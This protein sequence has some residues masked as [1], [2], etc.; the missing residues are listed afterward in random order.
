MSAASNATD[1]TD[2]SIER[3]EPPPPNTPVSQT[4]RVPRHWDRCGGAQGRPSR[5][6]FVFLFLDD[7]PRVG[8]NVLAQKLNGQMRVQ[9][10]FSAASNANFRDCHA[11]TSI[12]RIKRR[13]ERGKRREKI[14][15]LLTGAPRR[16]QALD[17]VRFP[18]A[19]LRTD[20][21]PSCA[22]RRR[23]AGSPPSPARQDGLRPRLSL[24]DSLLK[25]I[26]G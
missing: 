4:P 25:R 2:K 11:S 21:T 1:S 6:P 8:G 10:A 17:G 20:R 19:A 24:S 23:Q 13:R 15:R 18:A 5:S 9:R 14:I 16:L 12:K 22:R 7:S 26:F 3:I